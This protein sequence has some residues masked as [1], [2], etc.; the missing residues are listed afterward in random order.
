MKKLLSILVVLAL[1]SALLLA[2]SAGPASAAPGAKHSSHSAQ[3]SAPA[4][5]TAGPQDLKGLLAEMD[6]A[7]TT[8]KAAQADFEWDQ[9]Q[10]VVDEHDVQKGQIYFR[11]NKGGVDA[12]VKIV[13]PEPKQVLFK[14]G[15]LSLYQPKIDQVTEYKAGQNRA[16]VESFMSL[17]FGASGAD[18]AKNFEIK[19]L[20]WETVDGVKTAKLD[21][22][23]KQEKVKS[24]LSHVLLWMDPKRNVSIKQQFFEPSGDYRLTH[25][26]NINVNG[27][28]SDDVF[29]LKTTSRTKIV[30]PQ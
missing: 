8:F 25:Y 28:I 18:L 24:S 2:R 17:G 11:K 22:T 10:R 23:P 3:E 20:G 21:L 29:R 7:A 30:Q 1:P 27:R 4:Q 12:A 14:D 15:K 26:T 16:E 9:Y 13:S 5:S 19:L 6:K